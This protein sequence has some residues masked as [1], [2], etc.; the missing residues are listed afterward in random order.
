MDNIINK[1]NYLFNETKA[2]R[3]LFYIISSV[4]IGYT[5]QPVPV[6][7]NEQFNTNS[8]LKYVILVITGMYLTLPITSEKLMYILVISFAILQLFA[9]FRT[10]DKK[11]ENQQ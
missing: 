2:F 11:E 6:W 10:L 3:F 9:Y 7:L 8:I 4:F 5:L 1:I